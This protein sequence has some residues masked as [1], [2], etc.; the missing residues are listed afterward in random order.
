MVTHQRIA[1]PILMPGHCS[2]LVKYN[3]SQHF[4]EHTSNT[5][6]AGICVGVVF[7]VLLLLSAQLL[8]FFCSLHCLLCGWQ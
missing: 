1:K 8:D 6:R 4:F 2:E 7:V 3:Q 5:A